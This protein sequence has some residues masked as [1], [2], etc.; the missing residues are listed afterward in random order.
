MERRKG[1]DEAEE[2]TGG[3]SGAMGSSGHLS[4]AGAVAPPARGS[5]E[6]TG[7]GVVVDALGVGL[8]VPF[9]VLGAEGEVGA[10]PRAAGAPPPPGYMGLSVGDGVWGQVG[11]GHGWS[12]G[13][14]RGGRARPG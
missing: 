2:G 4:G 1:R 5:A 11:R 10:S 9:H 7:A 6:G 12:R 8:Q 14:L 13:E 3:V